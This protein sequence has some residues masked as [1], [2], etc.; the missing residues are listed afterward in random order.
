M[1]SFGSIIKKIR[2]EKSMSKERLS[3]GICSFER[4]TNIEDGT[5]VPDLFLMKQL[6]DRLF[7]TVDEVLYLYESQKT[8]TKKWLAMMNYFFKTMQYEKL[9]EICDEIEKTQSQ[10]TGLE[11]QLFL[12]Y[13]GQVHIHLS[14][15]FE[16]ALECFRQALSQSYQKNSSAPTDMELIILNGLGYIY[17]ALGDL[18]KSDYFFDKSLHLFFTSRRINFR[19]EVIRI[20]YVTALVNIERQKYREAADMVNLGISWCRKKMSLYLLHELLYLKG[21][22]LEDVGKLDE[23]VYFVE[24]AERIN[25]IETNDKLLDFN[26][27]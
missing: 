9:K 15:E 25:E 21:M 4:L 14:K 3:E 19:P 6:C 11:R 22:I 20:F 26:V 7:M 27:N 24:L 23:A 18:E 13:Q 10:L 16:A 1:R 12:Y 2:L 17:Y 5:E 8:D